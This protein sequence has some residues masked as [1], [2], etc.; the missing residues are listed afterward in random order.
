MPI[1]TRLYWNKSASVMY[2]GIPP[3]TGGKKKFI[4]PEG[5]RD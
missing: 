1:S 2:M 3:F 4:P 5:E